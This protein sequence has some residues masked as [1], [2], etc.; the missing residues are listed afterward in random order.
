MVYIAADNNLESFGLSDINEMEA[1]TGPESSDVY[2]TTLIDRISGYSSAD[3]N[4]TDTRRGQIVSDSSTSTISSTLTSIGELNTG[5]PD[6]LTNFIN[7]SATN[8]P[9]ENYALVIWDHGGGYS[10]VAWDDSN[11]HDNLTLAEVT[12]AIDSSI[13]ESFGVVGYDACLMAMVEAAYPLTNYTDYFVASSELEPGDGWEYTGLMNSLF[14]NPQMSAQSLA[15]TMVEAYTNQFSANSYSDHTLS[16][17]NTD[18]LETLFDSLS[19]FST[20]V[21][22][23]A[24]SADWD[25]II[26]AH[27]EA[28]TYGNSSH[29]YS[30]LGDF[31]STVIGGSV[32]QSIDSA[33]SNVMTAYELAVDTSQSNMT[34]ASGLSMYFPGAGESVSSSY[35]VYSPEFTVWGTFLSELTQ[36]QEGR[37][38]SDLW[39]F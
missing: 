30:D 18:H 19:E 13:I 27:N 32:N 3:G 6:T 9:A 33:A 17:I 34:D 7:W 26:A 29:N 28:T 15:S 16:S 8:Y 2:V 10:G 12:S 38:E 22:D 31:M 24:S 11:G 36:Q 35:S 1:A 21:I 37:V 14:A 20:T 4:W 25:A 39:W 23:T 5:D